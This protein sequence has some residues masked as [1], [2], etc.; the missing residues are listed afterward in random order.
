MTSGNT[1]YLDQNPPLVS[2][3][4]PVYNVAPFLDRCIKSILNQTC[5]SLELLLIDDG[6]TDNSLEIC[7]KLG[8]TDTR[9]RIFKQENQGSSVARNLGLDHASGTYIAFVDS[10]DWIAAEML[11]AMVSSAQAN[12]LSVVECAARTS[13]QIRKEGAVS[14]PADPGSLLSIESMEQTME[15]L[16]DH[17]N[18][19]VW[20]RIYHRDSIGELRFIP[21]KIHQDVFFTLDVLN[22]LDK[23][24]YISIPYY[25]YNIDNESVIRSPYNSKKL[26]AIDAIYYVTDQ[27]AQYGPS[28]RRSAMKHVAEA[29]VY[30]YDS[31]FRN[32]DLDP[33]GSRRKEIRNNISKN[34]VPGTRSLYPML[35]KVLPPRLYSLFLRLNQK[36][37]S[38]QT[39]LLKR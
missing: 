24:G 39:A 11:E 20:R 34:L 25:N 16:I 14:T 37:I 31:L 6:S 5:P 28:V 30:H 32:P 12:A 27:T 29:L 8:E 3:I 13:V 21:R 1:P 33:D 19:A 35:A 26:D 36:R 17:L 4:V 23:I 15:R 9:I 38:L 2:V 7:Q 22:S 18:F 10:D